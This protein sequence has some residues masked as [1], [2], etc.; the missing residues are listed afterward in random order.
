MKPPAFPLVDFYRR[1]RPI[2]WEEEFGRRAPIE[3]EIGSGLGE[4]LTD[5]ARVSADRNFLGIEPDKNRMSKILKKWESFHFKNIRLLQTDARLVFER[6]LA[7]LTVERVHCLFPCPW[8]KRRHAKH[9][10]LTKEFLQ[11]VNSRLVAEGTMRIVTDFPAFAGW[12]QDQILQTG[13]LLKERLI[14]PQFNTK[15]EHKWRQAGVKEFFEL[16]LFKKEHLEVPVKEDTVLKEFVLKDLDCR[17]CRLT[18]QKGETSVVFKDYLYDPQRC[19]GMI[20]AIVVEKNLTQHLWI[21]LVKNKRGWRIAPSA[22]CS[23]LPTAGIQRALE[24]VYELNHTH[25]R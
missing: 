5:V 6:L 17:R 12:L 20:Y 21:T 11:L 13:F 4:F 18:N 25:E 15:F 22:G 16:E 9:R 7:P 14:G 23:F 24:L 19:K 10:L 8:P 1:R 2:S 3:V